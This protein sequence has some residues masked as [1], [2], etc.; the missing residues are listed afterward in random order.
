VTARAEVV[1]VVPAAEPQI[2]DRAILRVRGVTKR[3]GGLQ[4]LAGVDLD[5]RQGE[6]FGLVGP[7]GSGKTTLINVISGFYPL[8][9]G[10]ISLD[11]AEI[12][13]DPAH[14]IARRGVART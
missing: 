9:S 12:G 3:F 7:N 5:V 4:A 1:P 6:I 13:R 11:G 2:G 14:E 10:T 8:T